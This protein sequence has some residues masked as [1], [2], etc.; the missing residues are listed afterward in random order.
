[1]PIAEI[2][3]LSSPYSLKPTDLKEAL[4]LLLNADLVPFIEGPP[5]V[6]KSDI[7]AQLAADMFG[8]GGPCS[9]AFFRDIKPAGRDPVDFTGLPVP[10]MEAFL[11]QWLKPGFL[12]T[13]GE[14]VLFLDEFT[15]A[16]P[17]VQ[18]VLLEFIRQRKAGEYRL[19]PGWKIVTAGN[20]DNDRA[21]ATTMGSAMANRL[22][23]LHAVVD[24][25]DWCRWSIDEGLPA[26]IVAFVRF[27]P[28]LLH[29]FEPK[30]KDK[31]FASP[32]TIA[33]AGKILQQ[34]PPARLRPALL[35]GAIGEAAATELEGFLDVHHALPSIDQ[36]LLD[37]DRASVP[38]QQEAAA[39]CAIAAVL[40]ERSS[41]QNF[42]AVMAYADRL[43]AE[44]GGMIALG[45]TRR[46]P[47]LCKTRA[48]IRWS[49][50]NGNLMS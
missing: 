43:P 8:Q 11:T 37:P 48:F 14:G 30:S 26:V 2:A 7:V 47:T 3:T 19:P 34:D 10:D 4:P 38:S 27:R 45:A 28:H 13:D 16:G 44:L 35:A 15:A 23:H 25:D 42:D 17:L 22:V 39:R 50:E 33:D 49:A 41:P 1:M 32:R 12:P 24:V 46:D 29:N 21:Y 6:G 9:D 36:I 31:A 5:G 20:G 40:T 18:A